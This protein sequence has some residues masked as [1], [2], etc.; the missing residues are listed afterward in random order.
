MGYILTASIVHQTIPFDTFCALFKL[1]VHFANRPPYYGYSQKVT[2]ISHFLSVRISAFGQ[3]L[4]L[5]SHSRNRALEYLRKSRAAVTHAASPKLQ[6]LCRA[7]LAVVAR[8]FQGSGGGFDDAGGPRTSLC[9]E[10]TPGR[11]SSL[12]DR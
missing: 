11:D 3:L 10:P 12:D 1:S 8:A 2:S 7:S 5:S 9:G 4:A 6:G